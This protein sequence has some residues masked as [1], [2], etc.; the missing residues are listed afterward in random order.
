MVSE[1]WTRSNKSVYNL[2]YHIIWCPKYRRNV[3]V[4]GIDVR[5][6]ELLNYKAQELKI[7]IKEMEVMPDH[8]HIF[9]KADPVLSPHY[10]IQQF[11]GYTSRIL[12]QE[13]PVLKR[14]L[15]TLW[16]R[17]YYIESVGHISESVVR[18]YIEEQ[19]KV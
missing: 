16:T 6:K 11:K 14:K 3:L 12:R 18:K 8:I 7:E 5:L 17:S 19:K 1:R 15:P 13:F 4:N 9:I 2:G 10:I